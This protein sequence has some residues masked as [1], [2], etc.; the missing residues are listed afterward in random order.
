[1]ALVNTPTATK[2]ISTLGTDSGRKAF[3]GDWS[4]L[5]AEPGTKLAK[6][7]HAVGDAVKRISNLP[8]DKTRS[9]P[10]RHQ[11]GRKI[12]EA[13]VAQ[14]N[15]T[16]AELQSWAARETAAAMAQ[17]DAVLAPDIDTAA[18]VVRSEIRAFVRDSLK[19]D[20]AAEFTVELRGLVETD[21]R[22]A[23]ALLE[24]PAALS[25]VSPE[26]LN[27]L[28]LHAAAAHAPQAAERVRAASEIASLDRKLASVAAEV[29]RS[30]YDP[31]I[32][33][34]MASHVNIDVPL[35][36]GE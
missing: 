15:N 21:L 32:E 23:H 30:F 36:T 4:K 8:F 11:A 13:T 7:H 34:G 3:C 29:P 5:D 25:G 26:R 19:G 24:A 18:Q 10:Q 9:E 14:I 20:G 35:S 16:R 28:R 12:A 17:V 1:M 33:K 27:T 6:L 2:F 31:T 22:F